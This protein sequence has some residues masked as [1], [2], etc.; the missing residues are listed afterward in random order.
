L[1]N[2]QPV[3]R[4]HQHATDDSDDDALDVDTGHIGDS[5][6]RAGKIAADDRTDD[7][8]DDRG[9]QHDQSRRTAIIDTPPA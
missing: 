4:H 3:G 8:E 1:A 2:E 7:A 9:K 5:Q 6:D